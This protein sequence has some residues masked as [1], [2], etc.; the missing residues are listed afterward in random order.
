MKVQYYPFWEC[1]NLWYKQ[2]A[3][4]L[5]KNLT[6]PLTKPPAIYPRECV[7]SGMLKTVPKF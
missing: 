5:G 3:P 7:V 2:D 6:S 1:I 4:K